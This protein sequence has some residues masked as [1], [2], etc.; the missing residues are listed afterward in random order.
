MTRARRH[1]AAVTD[2]FGFNNNGTLFD[3]VGRR[4]FVSPGGITYDGFA[5]PGAFFNPDFA[6]N[7]GALN[8]NVHF[9]ALYTDGSFYERSDGQVVFLPTSPPTVPEIEA[10]VTR[11]K[12]RVASLL[13]KLGLLRR[14]VGGD[15]AQSAGLVDALSRGHE[16]S[17]ADELV[18]DG[19]GELLAQGSRTDVADALYDRIV[20]G[21]HIRA[22]VGDV[23]RRLV[24]VGLRH[25]DGERARRGLRVLQR[26]AQRRGCGAEGRHAA[27][28]CEPRRGRAER[29]AADAA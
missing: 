23:T 7:T 25:G 24:E 26:A 12:L 17:A 20:V 29:T 27:C 21:I 15:I 9:H 1:G 28:L 6:F 4:N 16:L 13:E 11:I 8:L 10:L 3:Y 14:H 22:D 19:G 18:I 5:Q 2:Q